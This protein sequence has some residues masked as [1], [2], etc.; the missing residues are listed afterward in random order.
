MK[1]D[2]IVKDNEGEIKKIVKVFKEFVE[3]NG[4]NF[5]RK[6]IKIRNE[7]LGFVNGLV[8]KVKSINIIEKLKEK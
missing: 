6:V 1:L 2:D 7:V 3:D 5:G 8:D 4:K